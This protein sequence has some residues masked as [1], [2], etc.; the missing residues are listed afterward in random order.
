MKNYVKAVLYAYP[1]LEKTGE[2][3]GVHIRN[4]AILSYRDGAPA[5]AQAEYIVAEIVEKRKLEWLKATLDRVFARL[6]DAQ[7]TLISLR[8]FG[9]GSKIKSLSRKA[10][11][12]RGAFSESKYF[13][14]QER[15]TETVRAMLYGEGL[16]EESFEKDFSQ[17]ELFRRIGARMR[18]G[19][20]YPL[21]AKCKMQNAE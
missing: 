13:R 8:Y 18:S 15:L 14:L 1:W 6:T 10:K 12:V 19:G 21:N 16:T 11:S 17:M 9:T 7:R 20:G 4:R 3:Y 5:V 2:A